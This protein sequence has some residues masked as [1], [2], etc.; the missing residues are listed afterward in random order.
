MEIL[1]H[2]LLCC[3]TGSKPDHETTKVWCTKFNRSYRSSSLY[4][5]RVCETVRRSKI[6]LRLIVG[7]LF[8][9]LPYIFL[10]QLEI[11]RI[12]SC[13]ISF[14]SKEINGFDRGNFVTT[15]KYQTF[16]STPSR[17]GDN[18]ETRTEKDK[19][20]LHKY[21]LEKRKNLHEYLFK[22]NPIA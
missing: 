2:D 19:P 7:W 13:L 3:V 20:H 5:R 16:T 17:V 14:S 9:L 12:R 21:L 1:T 18:A 10:V 8:Y 11:V 22:R 6:Q 4:R 15:K